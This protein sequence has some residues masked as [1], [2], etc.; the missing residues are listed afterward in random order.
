M[1][2]MISTENNLRRGLALINYTLPIHMW[3]IIITAVTIRAAFSPRT[4]QLTISRTKKQK[5]C[6]TG[7]TDNY[8][9][10]LPASVNAEFTHVGVEAT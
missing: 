4:Q 2:K 8:V 5:Q 9:T 7:I 10:F 3:R 6:R 1:V